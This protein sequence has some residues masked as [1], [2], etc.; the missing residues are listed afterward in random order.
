MCPDHSHQT[1]GTLYILATPIGN[2]E[3]ITLRALN[4]LREVD[5][6]FSEDTRKTAIL[7]N[8]NGISKKMKSFRVHEMDR[9]V[10][11]AL[12]LLQ[13]GMNLALV[14]DAGTP[15]ISDPGSHLV[16]RVRSELP[17]VGIVPIPGASALSTILSV[18]GW[19]T[20]PALFGGFLSIKSGKRKKFL[21]Q[22]T[23]FDGVIVLYESVHRIEKLLQ[24][25]RECLPGRDIL[26][27]R[28]MTKKFE[29]YVLF[30]HTLTDDEFQISSQ[31]I[32]RKGE[33]TVAIGPPFREKD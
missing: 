23:K 27:G 19:Q 1:R 15:G 14:T 6:I 22:Y 21:E 10:D 30:S 4:I 9:D 20:N 8:Q 17:E 11:Y 18:S 29:Q 28:E 5:L 12:E 7:L 16:R 2:L 24:E 33:F 32:V 25:I 13:K 31:E 3:D 26:V